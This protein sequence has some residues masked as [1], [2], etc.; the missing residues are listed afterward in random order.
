MS[1]RLTTRIKVQL[2]ILA[3]ISMVAGAVMMFGYVRLPAIF[4]VGHY[5]VTMQLPR[6]GGLYARANVT[7]R[8]VEV[9][10]V[11][12]VRLTD[13]AVEAVLSLR[14][15]VDIPS[16]LDAQV[17]SV[18]GV[19]EQYVA[20]LPRHGDGP[21]LAGGDVIPLSRTSV[22][23]DINALLDAANRGL[24]SIPQG[25]LKTVIDESYT[26]VGGLGPEIAR[27]VKGSTQ[28]AI[29]ARKNLD[30]LLELVDRSQ[31]VLDSQADSSAAIRTWAAH[32]ADLTDQLR[33][34]DASLAGL[35]EKGGPAADEAKQLI[36]R[37]QPTL[38]TLLSN[39]VHIGDVAVAYQ[40]A[41]EQILVLAPAIM[42][43]LQAT[44][45]VSDGTKHP[46]LNLDFNL[47]LNLP[48]PC[49]TG[50]LPVQQQRSPVL[51]DV[52]ERPDGLLYCRVPQ[53]SF[54]V[55]RGARNYPCATR[56]G[57]RAPSARMCESDEEYVP[58]NDGF[59]WKGDP[60][61]TLSGQDVP[62]PD[63]SRDEPVISQPT[64]PPAPFYDW[65][66]DPNSKRFYDHPTGTYLGPDGRTYTQGELGESTKGQTW[67]SMLVPPDGA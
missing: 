37:M 4:G 17:H 34:N 28:L 40:P 8:G 39:V 57:K 43:A 9:G 67:Q 18:S 19:G 11:T 52:P 22:A 59:N 25:N 10:R 15:D 27:F 32:L 14:S 31:P 54:N 33:T 51:E 23:P 41:I 62:Q 7:Y 60:N 48:P 13:S 56:P 63:G 64:L 1:E 5:A 21:P 47:N 45:M 65:I 53:D 35:L 36:D 12:D 49:T 61:A 16:D 50:F 24:Q 3:V 66:N 29:D 44:V 42:A 55:V 2:V 20:L 30:P 38:P 46:A 26:A 6:A 58:L